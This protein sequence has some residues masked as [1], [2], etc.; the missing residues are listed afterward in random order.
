MRAC[1]YVGGGIKTP[2]RCSDGVWER[3]VFVDWG[4]CVSVK[5]SVSA[6][7]SVYVCLSVC[8]ICL[9]ACVSMRVWACS[10]MCVCR[11]GWGNRVLPHMRS[12]D[13]V[14][15]ACVIDSGAKCPLP[16]VFLPPMRLEFLLSGFL[17]SFSSFCF[18]VWCFL[19]SF[20]IF[21]FFSSNIKNNHNNGSSNNSSSNNNSV[22]LYT[23]AEFALTRKKLVPF[24]LLESSPARGKTET[25]TARRGGA[26]SRARQVKKKPWYRWQLR[27][28]LTPRNNKKRG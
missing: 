24:P 22:N 8:L 6:F 5:K 14:E 9:C 12:D 26:K 18:K 20:F 17:S 1:V 28:Q 11:R 19:L 21:L 3:C 15:I 4:M 7:L 25:D 27:L 13:R 16:I 23:F 2:A 10:F